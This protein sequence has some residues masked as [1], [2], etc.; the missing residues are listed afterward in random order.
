MGEIML[1]CTLMLACITVG[2]FA[3]TTM[4]RS[5]IPPEPNDDNKDDE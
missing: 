2:A 5:L 3:G 1:E 4:G